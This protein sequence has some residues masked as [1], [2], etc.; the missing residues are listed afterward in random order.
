MEQRTSQ[1]LTLAVVTVLM[2]ASALAQETPAAPDTSA[3]VCK[4][5]PFPTGYGGEARL[6]AGY[7][8]ESSA[9]FGDFRG[10][11]DDGV[12]LDAAAAG[13][14]ALASG[15][16]LD[17]ALD[18]L[19]L[20]SRSAVIEGGK[21]GAY[22][23]GLSYDRIPHTPSDTGETIFSGVGGSDLR[24]PGGWVRAGST[25]GMT[26]LAS[27]LRGVEE[28]YDRDRFGL[29]GRFFVGD[30]W[31]VALDYKRDERNGTRRKYA[32]FGSAALELL[33][34][35]DDSTDRFNATVRYQGAR[36]FA[37]AGYY[38]SIY[39]S[40]A[41]SVRVENPFTA[42]AGG[43][44]GVLAL[45]PSNSYNEFALSAGWYGLPGNTAITVSGAAGTGT[46]DA[47]FVGYTLNPN[48]GVDAL[49]FANL[50]GDVSVTRADLALSARPLDRLRVR[51]NVAW[52]EREN[53][54]R[55]GVF[56][57]IV[58]TDLFPIGEDRVNR[59]YGFERLRVRGSADYA[60][61]DDLT[62]GVGGEWRSTDRTGT[63]QEVMSEEV[64]DGFG[65][66]QYRPTG[67]LGVVLKGGI[68]ERDP[69][70]YDAQAGLD[71][72]GQN[73][74]MR[75]FNQ[76]YRYRSYGELVA[77]A[78]LGELPLTLGASVYYGDDSYLQSDIGLV[79]G[80]DR[81]FGV[82]LNWTVSEK[83]AAYLTVTRE[84]IDSKTQNSSVFGFPDWRG[85]V[86]DD[87]ETYGGGV[88]ARFTDKLALNLDYTFG[89]G[90]TRHRLEG[91][92]AGSFPPVD[93][94]LSSLRADLTYGV[95]PRADVV[96]TWWNESLETRDWQFQSEPTVLPTLLGLGVDPYDYDVNYVVLSLRYRFG[97]AVPPSEE[98][99]E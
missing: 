50:D 92:G 20:D 46:Q 42:P 55:Q 17:Y 39:D 78:A 72:Y 8:D 74:L 90:K 10:L 22:E 65:R 79:S 76:A 87:Y 23:F 60:V 59:V 25:G 37:E 24:L 35:V 29:F 45:E 53:E 19:G 4:K 81:R 33:R 47:S 30:A 83:I 80:L 15:Y 57:S 31:S 1:I 82:D 93:S 75:K 84:K 70:N 14:V 49:P 51:G 86:E 41:E 43:D 97:T 68:E 48:L 62:V 77:D 63:R 40:K 64:L 85:E 12:H 88:S 13:G 95:N 66:V 56:T 54:S 71:L 9:K 58:H 28:G 61:Y 7:V 91:V 73:P 16:R 99:A 21:Q 96:L 18:D 67:W 52:D 38:G 2:S 6:G 26:A 3:W 27:S 69:D 36:W 11:E 44:A 98:A 5:C 34:P 89:D 32:S 94:Q